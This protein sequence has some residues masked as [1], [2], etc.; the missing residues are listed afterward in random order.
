SAMAAMANGRAIPVRTRILIPP[1]RAGRR[2]EPA[3]GRTPGGARRGLRGGR[4]R[5]AGAG[6]GLPRER[7]GGRGGG[8]PRGRAGGGRRGGVCFPASSAPGGAWRTS[9]GGARG[10]RWV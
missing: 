10:V 2:R 8:G 5:R 3:G 9:G 6:R 7:A 1:R 4:G